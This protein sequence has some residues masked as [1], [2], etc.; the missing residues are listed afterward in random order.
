MQN[1]KKILPSAP[2]II[3]E[4]LYFTKSK[5]TS[6]HFAYISLNIISILYSLEAVSPTSVQSST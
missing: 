5:L 1:K 6:F 3:M 2:L 4:V